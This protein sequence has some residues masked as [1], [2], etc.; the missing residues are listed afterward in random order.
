MGSG[1]VLTSTSL[2]KVRKEWEHLIM[3]AFTSSSRHYMSCTYG[4][5]PSCGIRG[6]L[7]ITVMEENMR[8]MIL[9][10]QYN[11]T[12]LLLLQSKEYIVVLSG[13]LMRNAASCTPSIGMVWLFEVI[14]A[15]EI[16]ADSLSS[17]FGLT[18]LFRRHTASPGEQLHFWFNCPWL[19]HIHFSVCY[20]NTGLLSHSA[21]LPFNMTFNNHKIRSEQSSLVCRCFDTVNVQWN[22]TVWWIPP[23]HLRHRKQRKKPPVHFHLCMKCNYC[24]R[25]GKGEAA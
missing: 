1:K 9:L 16:P 12:P 11:P 22:S 3:W 4:G 19:R 8:C 5:W 17:E 25:C 10:Q 2:L 24:E 6:E 13:M 21:R 18:H 14:G 15:L 7:G 23:P 20:K